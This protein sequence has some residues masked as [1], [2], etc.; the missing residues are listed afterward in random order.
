MTNPPKLAELL[1]LDGFASR[2]DI[3]RE[4]ALAVSHPAFG[5]WVRKSLFVGAGLAAMPFTV[6]SALSVSQAEE[7]VGRC[8][9]RQ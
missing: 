9:S 8:L 4:L 5:C 1:M 2:V 6:P 7:L 3:I